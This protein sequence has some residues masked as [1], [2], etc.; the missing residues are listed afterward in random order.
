MFKVMMC[1]FCE[2]MISVSWTLGVRAVRLKA[3]KERVVKLRISLD[4]PYLV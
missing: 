2:F 1:S 3:P 4:E